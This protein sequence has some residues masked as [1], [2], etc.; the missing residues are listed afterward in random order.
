[1]SNVAL[2]MAVVL[3]QFSCGFCTWGYL[4][5]PGVGCGVKRTRVGGRGPAWA[6]GADVTKLLQLSLPSPAPGRV[7]MELWGTIVTT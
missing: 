6:T 4:L 5:W 7:V 3:R 2:G 1:L